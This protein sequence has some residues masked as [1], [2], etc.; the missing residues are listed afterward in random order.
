MTGM[1]NSLANKIVKVISSTCNI[2]SLF[3]L[4]TINGE[5]NRLTI[6]HFTDNT[7]C[8]VQLL[9]DPNSEQLKTEVVELRTELRGIT[10]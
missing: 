1:N 7:S 10:I 5:Q 2:S 6:V 4:K 9:P 3:I 8:L